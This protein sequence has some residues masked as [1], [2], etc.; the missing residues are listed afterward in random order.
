MD[1]TV[2]FGIQPFWFW[3]GEMED[4]EIAKQVQECLDN[5]ITMSYY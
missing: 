4:G 5:R 2:R 1:R 3:N